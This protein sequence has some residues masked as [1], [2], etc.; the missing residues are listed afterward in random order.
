MSYPV[1]VEVDYIE[2]R[3]RLTSFFRLLL[4]IPLVIAALVYGIGVLIA[5]VIAWF[6]LLFTGRW[7]AGLYEFAAGVLRFTARYTGYVY[8]AVD[9]Y[10][11]F[12]LGPEP[13]YPLRVL[14]DPPQP[15]YSRLKVL[16]RIFY[17]IPPYVVA[18]VLTIVMELIAIVSW[19][20][21]VITGRQPQGL[22]NAIV[23]CLSYTVRTYALMY[24]LTETYPP[25]N[26]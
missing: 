7:P 9:P 25:F 6:A 22:Q 10:P 11:P 21:I 1:T 19:L 23:F 4:A 16:L 8:L 5:I 13:A 17:V 20:V 18:Y 26:P 14:I 3:S 24:L 15:S 2:R 12:G